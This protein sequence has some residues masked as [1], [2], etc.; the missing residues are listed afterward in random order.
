MTFLLSQVVVSGGGASLRPVDRGQLCGETQRGVWGDRSGE[1]KSPE[2]PC[3]SHH[4]PVILAFGITDRKSVAELA[5]KT[6]WTSE[7]CVQQ[8]TLP[9]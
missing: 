2:Q 1:F 8:E 5:R 6:G 4:L 7:H 9:Q 3:K